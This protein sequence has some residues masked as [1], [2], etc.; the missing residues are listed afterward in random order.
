MA[1]GRCQAKSRAIVH[2]S[3]V[4]GSHQ[5]RTEYISGGTAIA[6]CDLADTREKKIHMIG[7]LPETA[8]GTRDEP[9]GWKSSGWG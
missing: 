4:S 7:I 8:N 5:L 9:P 6:S 3:K 2:H 1:D